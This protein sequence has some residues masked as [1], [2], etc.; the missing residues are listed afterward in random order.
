M[1]MKALLLAAG[2][3]TRLRPVTDIVPKCLVPIHG[4]PL[5]EYWL[6]NLV[7]IGITEILINTSY[8]HQQVETYIDNSIY[9]NSVTLVYEDKLLNTGGTIL[10]NRDFFDNEPF[11]LIHADNFSFFDFDA[12]INAHFQRPTYCEMTMMLFESTNPSSCGIV[13]LNKEKV[14][15]AFYEKVNNPPSNL[16]NG[17]VYICEPTILTF[18][19]SLNKEEIDFSLEV[20][21]SYMG[22]IYTY[23]NSIY[24]KD[25]G[26]LES[27]ALAQ[28]D[29][30]AYTS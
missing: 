4:K 19:E 25:I 8:L 3:G 5:L 9:K 26:T 12:F 22:K 23:L 29:S 15:S 6:E 24:H 7:H 18:L 1:K 11:I 14:V 30:L 27:Y 10:K 2:L 17:A 13:V 21:P 16:A 28:V 20:I